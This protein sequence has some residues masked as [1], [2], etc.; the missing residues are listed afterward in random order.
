M[1]VHSPW[2]CANTSRECSFRLCAIS[3]YGP[4]C[5]PA[6]WAINTRA[7][8][9]REERKQFTQGFKSTNAHMH[10]CFFVHFY[11]LK[12][13]HNLYWNIQELMDL[14]VKLDFFFLKSCR[15]GGRR[16]SVPLSWHVPEIHQLQKPLRGNLATWPDAA[17]NRP[18]TA[19]YVRRW[20]KTDRSHVLQ[21]NQVHFKCDSQFNQ[22][23]NAI[24]I[25]WCWTIYF[26]TVSVSLLH[27]AD[28]FADPYPA[29]SDLSPTRSCS[30][31]TL[32][33]FRRRFPP[34]QAALQW[35]SDYGEAAIKTTV[36]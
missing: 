7:L 24:K 20:L 2:S 4:E 27:R 21:V 28:I 16:P 1:C 22:P 35:T 18:L 3:S 25:Y 19:K 15:D 23:G 29:V 31:F 33:A 14:K 12:C 5:S 8:R 6:P 10:S 36:G 26:V 9:G 11:L 34:R 30:G 32:T 13:W 17:R